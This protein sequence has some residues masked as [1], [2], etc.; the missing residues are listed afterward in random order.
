MPSSDAI[1]GRNFLDQADDI[2]GAQIHY[3]YVLPLDGR[4]EQLDVN[5]AIAAS[6]ASIQTWLAQQTGGRRLRVDTFQGRLDVTFFRLSETDA[7][8]TASGAYVRDRIEAELKTS[9]MTRAGKLYG[10]FYGGGSTYACGGGAWP[11]V[12]PGIVAAQYLKGTPPGATCASNPVGA[13]AS[14]PAY[15]DFAMLH[16][17]L[18]TMGIVGAC[19]PHFTLAG[20]VSDDPRDLMYAGPL[21]WRPSLLDVGHDDYYSHNNPGCP[22]LAKLPWLG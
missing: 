11:P 8:I 5:G 17:L 9:G 1:S 2:G 13:S 10:V 19:A 3:M 7:Q 12:L 6:V 14:L 22:D 18:H 20:H 15:E 4:D 16:E 21:P